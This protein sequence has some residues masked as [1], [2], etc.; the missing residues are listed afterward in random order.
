MLYDK[1]SESILLRMHPELL[2]KMKG[3]M[4]P[5]LTQGYIDTVVAAQGT[6][7]ALTV[8]KVVFDVFFAYLGACLATKI[9]FERWGPG[10]KSN[11]PPEGTR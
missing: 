1:F 3:A 8:T 10:V 6:F 9:W 11:K 5:A 7:Y 2:E 4:E